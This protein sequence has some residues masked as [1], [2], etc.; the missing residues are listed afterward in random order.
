MDDETAPAGGV[1][2]RRAAGTRPSRPRAAPQK[3]TL[4][5]PVPRAR[6]DILRFFVVA[7]PPRDAS[8]EVETLDAVRGDAARLG[9]L[10]LGT[11]SVN[12]GFVIL[13]AEEEMPA[14]IGRMGMEHVS[15]E[16]SLAMLF[17]KRRQFA[18]AVRRR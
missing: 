6:R 11:E 9:P 2:A 3:K 4:R 1:A 7:M 10:L 18:R 8:L 12:M 15:H 16:H 5:E 14:W 13:D 17:M